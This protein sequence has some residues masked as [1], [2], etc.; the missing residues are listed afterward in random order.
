[1]LEF[2]AVMLAMFAILVIAV[3]VNRNLIYLTA[4]A[5]NGIILAT[6]DYSL[7]ENRYIAILSIIIFLILAVKF[8]EHYRE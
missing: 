7:A 3:L 1:M 8:Y 2:I 4:I 6:L 5:I